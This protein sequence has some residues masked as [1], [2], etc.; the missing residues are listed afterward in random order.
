MVTDPSFL[1]DNSKKGA[2]RFVDR[3]GNEERSKGMV[4]EAFVI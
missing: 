3:E 2:T 1:L 4:F